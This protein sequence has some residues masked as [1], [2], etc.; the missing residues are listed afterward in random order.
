MLFLYQYCEVTIPTLGDIKSM[1]KDFFADTK[2]L[3]QYERK[4]FAEH[5]PDDIDKATWVTRA[6]PFFQEFIDFAVYIIRER[7]YSKCTADGYLRDLNNFLTV[8]LKE[9]NDLSS[10]PEVEDV[11]VH[12]ALRKI[13]RIENKD[14]KVTA[15][16][17]ARLVSALKSFYKYEKSVKKIQNNFMLNVDT[18]KYRAHLPQYLT[19]AQFE[20]LVALPDNPSP[21]D[22][23]D[24]AIIELLFS[25]GIRVSELVNIKIQDID[26][27]NFEI[28]I[29]G[30][31][32]KE[33]I[34]PFGSYALNAI[35]LWLN[36]RPSYNPKVDNLFVNCF[37][38]ALNTRAIQIMIKKLGE[39][40]CLPLHATPHKLRHSFATEMISN[41]ADLRTVQEI[42]G[43][44]S[45]GVTQLY[46]HLDSKKLQENYN[47]SHPLVI[48]Q[49][50]E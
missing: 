25:T 41:G 17:K 4:Y 9:F 34:V 8:M 24:K 28:F 35:K 46:L 50:Q 11:H 27:Y 21:K 14:A 47:K 1:S 40:L 19:Y 20:K 29:L 23:R 2:L 32:N 5:V 36:N 37:G 43:H 26:F 13:H 49:E 15:R 42:L 33:R 39:E 22:Y 16:S 10:W 18:P 7:N 38:D 31:G 3:E 45:L 48:K 6:I 30:K 12:S 44:S